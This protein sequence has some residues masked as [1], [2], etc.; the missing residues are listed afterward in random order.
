M[1]I[2]A[3]SQSLDMFGMELQN[4][5]KKPT[6]AIAQS[7]QRSMM[8]VETPVVLDV[9]ASPVALNTGLAFDG[10]LLWLSGYAEYNL[11]GIDPG[12][13]AVVETI[14]IDFIRPYGLT[15]YDGRFYVVNNDLHQIIEIDRYTGNVV[16]VNQ[17]ST[18][19]SYPTGVEVISGQIWYNDPQ[20]PFVNSSTEDAVVQYNCNIADCIGNGIE[21]EYPSA[22]AYDG[23]AL[24]VM[25]NNT[26]N[27][28]KVNKQSF[29]TELLVAAPG[30]QYPNGLAFDGE[31]MWVSNNAS[32][33]IYKL[34]LEESTTTN[35]SNDLL[36]MEEEIKVFPTI[37]DNRF[38]I[39]LGDLPIEKVKIEL[40]DISGHVVEK[41]ENI[42]RSNLS[43]ENTDLREGLYFFKINCEN[44]D[45]VRKVIVKK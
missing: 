20:G 14:P 37:S 13:G 38:N 28:C 10:T 17:L 18:A 36:S 45:I 35:L 31:F 40:I 9:F 11:Y 4:Q 2:G 32:D 34:Q 44:K 30:G 29:E 43:W 26:Q 25:D 6:A 16:N 7:T 39:H 33:S 8:D 42:S 22:L 21:A 23:E 19:S 41:K 5:A 3:Y 24:W 12:T 1:T 27:I 15:Y